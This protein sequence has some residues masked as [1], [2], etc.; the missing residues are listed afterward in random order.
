M[1]P[2]FSHLCLLDHHNSS[3]ML[4]FGCFELKGVLA[5]EL[6][7]FYCVLA[8][9]FHFRPLWLNSAVISQVF[10][11]YHID[12]FSSFLLTFQTMKRSLLFAIGLVLFSQETNQLAETLEKQENKVE[13]NAD[14][15]QF[16]V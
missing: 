11:S 12:Q 7:V 6:T 13:K 1:K 4:A 15:G 14:I 9:G 2:W 3:W 16:G 10:D 5:F 8:L